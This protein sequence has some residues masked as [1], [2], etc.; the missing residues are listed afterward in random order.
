[1][2]LE[3]AL[4]F[5]VRIQVEDQ[6]LEQVAECHESL[7]KYFQSEGEL[8][9]Q[10]IA[11]VSPVYRNE[12]GILGYLE[13]SRMQYGPGKTIPHFMLEHIP[14][15]ILLPDNTLKPG[16]VIYIDQLLGV[17]EVPE[18]LIK[19]LET[20][21]RK[22]SKRAQIFVHDFKINYD[23]PEDLSKPQ[24]EGI[25]FEE[26][27]Y[28]VAYRPNAH[29]VDISDKE[30]FASRVKLDFA[31]VLKHLF[32]MQEWLR[33][34]KSQGWNARKLEYSPISA[35]MIKAGSPLLLE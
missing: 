16:N 13:F 24:F 6:K 1:M 3:K 34:A 28:Y 23:S 22:K 11:R 9:F 5:P 35:D 8:P 26:E 30:A 25:P 32:R 31:I 27:N 4:T 21:S 2:G 14:A 10:V 12:F 19:S 18:S 29:F 17:H 33:Y 7:K 15:E 20:G